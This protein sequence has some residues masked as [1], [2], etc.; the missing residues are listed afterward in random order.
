MA[1]PNPLNL[2]TQG[3]DCACDAASV[4][5]EIAALTK[6]FN[7]SAESIIADI[8]AIPRPDLTA[9]FSNL[10]T[11][12]KDNPTS[13]GEGIDKIGVSS[14]VDLAVA[15]GLPNNNDKERLACLDIGVIAGVAWQLN[16]STN[17]SDYR[18]LYTSLGSDL[19]KFVSAMAGGYGKWFVVYTKPLLMELIS[20][21]EQP[22]TLE[23]IIALLGYSVQREDVLQST[24][25]LGQKVSYVYREQHLGVNQTLQSVA[26]T[27]GI[28]TD[29][30]GVKVFNFGGALTNYDLLRF[31]SFGLSEEMI[32]WTQVPSDKTDVA[33]K[34][35]TAQAFMTENISEANLASAKNA[36]RAAISEYSF[37]TISLDTNLLTTLRLKN[38]DGEIKTG[39]DEPWIEGIVYTN[40]D[41]LRTALTTASN[42]EPGTHFISNCLL[43][44]P[45]NQYKAV[46]LRLLNIDT[47]LNLLAVGDDATPVA[48]LVPEAQ[49]VILTPPTPTVPALTYK[50]YDSG[51]SLIERLVDYDKTFKIN[52]NFT[53]I[54]SST[55]D[56]STL[57]IAGTLAAG[58]NAAFKVVSNLNQDANKVIAQIERMTTLGLCVTGVGVFENSF[59]KC[60]AGLNF[61]FNY[62]P[63]RDLI[64]TAIDA[65]NAFID[66]ISKALNRLVKELVCKMACMQEALGLGGLKNLPFCTVLPL[67]NLAPA[68]TQLA[69]FGSL[70][71]SVS[72]KRISGQNVLRFS[73]T[74][75]SSSFSDVTAG[76][77]CQPLTGIFGLL[78]TAVPLAS[79][80]VGLITHT[81][82]LSGSGN[83]K[84]ALPSFPK[85]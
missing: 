36:V 71:S 79:V 26:L 15:L 75:M 82:T 44:A 25:A 63:L 3:G 52:A 57:A 21:T 4:A 32:G 59:L 77:D 19:N 53:S 67:I 11:I 66:G 60:A 84:A 6:V 46:L 61:N 78:K 54:L 10:E 81:P 9:F 2:D 12:L 68:L 83:T 80:A 73:V 14:L 51:A 31:R 16:S 23:E 45:I 69:K 39:L 37:L 40:D 24:N 13:T 22:L 34:L 35:G 56:P 55:T 48:D 43:S 62:N 74:D 85:F 65:V 50:S 49:A 18:T 29:Q 47:L 42:V 17:F 38:T 20:P 28:T 64:N 58:Y 8:A 70:L 33:T 1:G 27:N 7:D 72:V 76:C 41:D 5:S 30:V